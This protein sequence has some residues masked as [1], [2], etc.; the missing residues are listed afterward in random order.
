MTHTNGVHTPH[1]PG[2]RVQVVIGQGA[3]NRLPELVRQHGGTRVLLVTDP[4]IKAAGHVERA[5]RSLYKADIPVRVFDEVGENP[6]T[7]HVGLGVIACKGFNPDLVIGLGGGSSMDCG[8]GINFILTNGGRM[9]DYWG[10]DKT[11]KP[12]LPFIAVPTTAGTGSDAQSYA[13]I[14]D[15]D[16]HQKM[17]C[18]DKTA[19]PR[20]ALLD[21]DLTATQPAKVAAA[22]GIDAIAHAVESAGST[23]RNDVSRALSKQAWTLLE[24]AFETAMT[25]PA[26][27]AA[28]Q[29]MLLGAHLAGAAIENSMLGAA[30]SLAN[31][32]TGLCDVVHGCAVGMMLPHVI[33]FNSANGDSPYAD[34]IEDPHALAARVEAM[35]ATGGLPRTL[36]EVN[37]SPTRL[38]ELA[39]MAAR[40]WTAQFNPR[41]VG[42]PEMLELYRMAQ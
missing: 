31:P 21:P 28:R 41:K 32:L 25:H 15:P 35:L 33:R 36:S 12:L 7:I 16:T 42:E 24:S 4:G 3:M 10:H 17:A 14:T 30:H 38:A 39:A 2:S 8:K 9:A 23:K 34:L 37:V 6:T 5:V 26:D 11:T 1:I 20:I 19:L 13:L 22:T 29:Q 18:G 27:V 40:Q